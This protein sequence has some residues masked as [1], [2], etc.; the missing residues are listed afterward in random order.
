MNESDVGFL[1]RCCH[2]PLFIAGSAENLLTLNVAM[3][4]QNTTQRCTNE[5]NKLT[6]TQDL[7]I[8]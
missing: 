4:P 5:I 1:K 7:A 2:F 3:V 8:C 6:L